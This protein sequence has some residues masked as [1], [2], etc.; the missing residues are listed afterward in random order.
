MSNVLYN[1]VAP[2]E[3]IP[4]LDLKLQYKQFEAQVG[5][6]L[7]ELC[8]SQAFILG[9]EVEALEKELGE[10]LGVKHAIGVSS[11]TDALLLSL[12]CLPKIAGKEVITSP[13]T[14][15]ATAGSISRAGARAKFVDIDPKTFNMNLEQVEEQLKEETAAVMPVHLFGQCVDMPRLLDIC[16]KYETPVIEDACQAIGS[17]CVGRQAGTFGLSGC[18]SFFPSKNLGAFGDAGLVCTNDSSFAERL[19][20]MRV[21]GGVRRYYHEEVGGNFRIDA[22]QAAILRI[23]L[24]FLNSWAEGRRRNAALYRRLF[25]EAGLMEEGQVYPSVDAPVVFPTEQV[26]QHVY[27]QF[28]IRALNRDD[29]QKKLEAERVGTAIYYPLCLHMQQC[30]A[31]LGFKQGDFPESER[32]ANESLALPIYPE[33]KPE[34]IERVVGVIKDFYR[35]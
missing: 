11:G 23:K 3:A 35:H 34:Q 12:M 29:L 6:K 22:L 7:L 33:L 1:S 32:A 30:F 19:F 26:P 14:F 31:E 13:Y 27:N 24:P 17:T 5:P 2:S 8:A 28:C 15:F 9:P 16:A 25:Q 20:K 10:Y 18:F 4:L 21:H